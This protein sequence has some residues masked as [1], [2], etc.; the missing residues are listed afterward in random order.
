MAAFAH[1]PA[2][3]HFLEN[4]HDVTDELRLEEVSLGAES[5]IAGSSLGDA[6][7]RA[8]SGALVVALR[9]DDGRLESNPP[10]DVV[11]TPGTTLVVIGTDEQ[12]ASL[13]QVLDGGG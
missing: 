10:P 5:P 12:L 13:A 2:V 9:H 3:A 6:R 1:R 11:L 4:V 8:R 7:L